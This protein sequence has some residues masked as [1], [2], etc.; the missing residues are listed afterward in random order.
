MNRILKRVLPIALILVI[1][2]CCLF[3]CGCN[4]ETEIPEGMKLAS[5]STLYKLFVPEE[6]QINQST[7]SMVSAQASDTDIANVSVMYW[8]VSEEC[9]D[10]DSFLVE[11]KLQ[12]EGVFTDVQFKES[13]TSSV[14]GE[15]YAVTDENGNKTSPYNARD[16]VYTAKIAGNYYKYHVTVV[17]HGGVFYVITFTFPQD[18]YGT[19]YDKIE[20]V[21]FKSY[22][23]HESN[24]EQIL[25]V[26]KIG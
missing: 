21:G 19:N 4:N 13:G 18:N 15:S 9:K 25:K 1:C 24:I 5:S 17:L 16:Y 7:P 10:H 2:T 8:Q 3:G 11:Y 6:W 22:T 12:I 26:F 14:V 23:N 20:D